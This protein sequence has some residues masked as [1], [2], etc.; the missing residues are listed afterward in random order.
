[1]SG[2]GGG[3]GMRDFFRFSKASGILT[4][5]PKNLNAVELAGLVSCVECEIKESDGSAA[6]VYTAT[7]PIPAGAYVLNVLASNEALWTSGTSAEMIIGD[8][9]DDNGYLEACSVK[10]TDLLL[11]NQFD[12]VFK[13]DTPGAYITGGTSNDASTNRYYSAAN[14]VIAKVTTVGTVGTAG[15]T[16]ILV[17]YCKPTKVQAAYVAS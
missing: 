7:I 10:A 3:Y 9:D 1:M 14:N 4:G 15:K 11:A 6:G 16:R 2:H 5:Q 8:D 13:S 17:V 12:F